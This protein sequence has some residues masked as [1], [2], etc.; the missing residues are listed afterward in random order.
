[1]VAAIPVALTSCSPSAVTNS[2]TSSSSSA[3]QSSAVAADGPVAPRTCTPDYCVPAG[4]DTALAST[5]LPQ[6]PPFSEPLNVI[7]GARSTVTLAQLQQALG[8]N[9]K[10]V[11]TATEVN[12]AGIRIRCISAEKADVEGD[13]YVPEQQSW[14]LGGCLKGNELSLTGNELHVRFWSQQVPGSP[15]GAWFGAASYETMCVDRDA[16]LQPAVANKT[17]TILHPGAAYH[18]VDGGQGT[19]T[20]LHPNG[21]DDGATDFA[22][23]VEAAA[24]AKGWKVAD[25][26]ITRPATGSD[27]GEGKISFSTRIYVITITT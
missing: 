8:S 12:V 18:C 4:W 5:P 13:G 24:T 19:F 3:P 22:H 21:Y 10:N 25:Q 17:W 14:R 15:R 9:W 23:A 20:S 27:L 16:R 11:S 26:V 2:S 1:M 7:I 6:V